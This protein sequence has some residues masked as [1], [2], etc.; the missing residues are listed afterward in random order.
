MALEYRNNFTFPPDSSVHNREA[1][2]RVLCR[3]FTIDAGTLLIMPRMPG[4]Q[5][6]YEFLQGELARRDKEL[7]LL[8]VIPEMHTALPMSVIVADEILATEY[9]AGQLRPITTRRIV[10]HFDQQQLLIEHGKRTPNGALIIEPGSPV[11]EQLTEYSDT[12]CRILLAKSWLWGNSDS[13]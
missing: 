6:I 9:I 11:Q 3:G 2:I 10:S 5:P 8:G 1:R 7:S 12:T 13:E 4:T